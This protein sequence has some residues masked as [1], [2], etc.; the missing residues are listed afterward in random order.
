M[1]TLVHHL[2]KRV[3]LSQLPM[4]LLDIIPP[5]VHLRSSQEV[6]SILRV[7]ICVGK[8]SPREYLERGKLTSRLTFGLSYE[9]ARD[10]LTIYSQILSYNLPGQSAVKFWFI[11]A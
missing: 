3:L 1:E 8:K 5:T 9:F 11:V 7:W 4:E 2:D 10:C 6:V